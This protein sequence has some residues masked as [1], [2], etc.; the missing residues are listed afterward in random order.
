[1][2]KNVFLANRKTLLVV[3]DDDKILGLVAQLMV[4]CGHNVM[5][6][7]SGLKAIQESRD[8]K[9]DIDLLLSDF[10]MPKMSGVDLATTLTLE[11][12]NIKVLLMSGFSGGTLI[13]NEGWHFLAK[14]F[15]NSQLSAL[16]AGLLSQEK[17]FKTSDV[18][19]LS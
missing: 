5:T 12:P 8:F 16:V 18:S 3:D 4:D 19:H 6:A 11:R 15:V 13:L 7:S 2:Q 14:P 1:M 9:G 17:K 10:Q